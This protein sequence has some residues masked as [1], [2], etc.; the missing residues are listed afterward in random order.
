MKRACTLNHFKMSMQV[1]EVAPKRRKTGL[2]KELA[3]EEQKERIPN[4]IGNNEDFP[5][6][7]F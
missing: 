1:D 2:P 5:A 3:N 6:P 7:L 4:V